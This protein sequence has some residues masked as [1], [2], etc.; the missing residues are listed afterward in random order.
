[1]NEPSPQRLAYL[2]QRQRKRCL[3]RA[4]QEDH[5]ALGQDVADELQTSKRIV[6]LKVRR[7]MAHDRLGDPVVPGERSAHSEQA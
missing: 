6:D 5:R 1:M 4:L 2:R 3:I 7:H